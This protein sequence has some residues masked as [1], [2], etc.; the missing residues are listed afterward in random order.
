VPAISQ[1]IIEPIWEQ[2]CALLPQRDAHAVHSLG[3]HRRCIPDR[4]VFDKLVQVLVFDCAYDRISDESCSASVLR[5]WRDEGSTPGR[6]RS[7]GGSRLKPTIASLV[8][9]SRT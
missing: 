2:F 3:C 6:W 5:R 8:Y 4:V 9:G 1:Y 7:C